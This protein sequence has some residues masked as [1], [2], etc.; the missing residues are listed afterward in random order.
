M[1][2]CRELVLRRKQTIRYHFYLRK[3]KCSNELLLF[4]HISKC[5]YLRG[6]NESHERRQRP[7]I[8]QAWKLVQCLVMKYTVSMCFQNTNLAY[9]NNRETIL[10][11]F[12]LLSTP[13]VLM[14]LPCTQCN[15]NTRSK[16]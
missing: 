13:N 3:T 14:K 16:A 2:L 4:P 6:R 7:D 9:R 10:P 15:Q 1:Q 12:Y 11:T 5:R 8:P